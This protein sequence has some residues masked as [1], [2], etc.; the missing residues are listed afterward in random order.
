MDRSEHGDDE[1]DHGDTVYRGNVRVP[2]HGMPFPIGSET[3]NIII[4][5]RLSKGK[6]VSTYSMIMSS[7]VPARKGVRSEPLL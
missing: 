7:G 4:L 1:C 5:N 2:V 6:I 3:V